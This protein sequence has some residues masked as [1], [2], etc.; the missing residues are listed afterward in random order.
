MISKVNQLIQEHIK[1]HEETLVMLRA[2]SALINKLHKELE[3]AGAVISEFNASDCRNEFNLSFSG[4]AGAFKQIWA[5]LRKEGYKPGSRPE[6]IRLSSFCTWW[7]KE[8]SM[9]IWFSF[10][11]TQCKVVKV[12][13]KMVEQAVYETQCDSALAELGV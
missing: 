11:S 8:E 12:G 13:T 4:T 1:K 10:S 2:S 6:E 9:Q 7:Y 5:F 3:A